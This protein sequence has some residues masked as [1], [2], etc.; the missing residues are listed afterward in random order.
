MKKLE[1]KI[2]DEPLSEITL[3]CELRSLTC[4]LR[5]R[6]GIQTLTVQSNNGLTLKFK[7]PVGDRGRGW[8]EFRGKKIFVNSVW[9]ALNA[10]WRAS[11]GDFDG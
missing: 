1:Q 6:L 9:A 8:Y 3:G 7:A 4:K 2:D 10:I 11:T 5:N